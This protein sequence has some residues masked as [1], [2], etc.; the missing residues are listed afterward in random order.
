MNAEFRFE[1]GQRVITW[2]AGRYQ[3]RS[4]ERRQ[5]IGLHRAGAGSL[6]LLRVADV[7]GI[8]TEGRN[9]LDILR[10]II[11]WL[12]DPENQE[13]IMEIVKFIMEILALFGVMFSLDEAE[14]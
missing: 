2:L 8:P 6:F 10:D 9:W 5:L 3:L 7:A 1:L 4:L 14:V 11:E 12:G 13:K